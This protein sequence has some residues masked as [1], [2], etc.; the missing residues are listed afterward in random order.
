MMRK[1]SYDRPTQ[2]YALVLRATF[3]MYAGMDCGNDV[4]ERKHPYIS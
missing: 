4:S 3:E 1:S 2:V